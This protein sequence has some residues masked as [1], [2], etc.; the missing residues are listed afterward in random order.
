MPSGREEQNSVQGL[1]QES[2]Q[3]LGPTDQGGSVVLEETPGG[4]G[5]DDRDK[6]DVQD[7]ALG[8]GGKEITGDEVVDQPVQAEARRARGGRLQA[9]QAGGDVAGKGQ[10]EQG[11]EG[12]GHRGGS[13]VVSEGAATDAPEI[14]SA[15]QRGVDGDQNQRQ[16]QELEDGDEDLPEPGDIG[17]PGREKEGQG[18]A[19]QESAGDGVKVAQGHGGSWNGLDRAARG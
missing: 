17:S 8:Q 13:E 19:Q 11:P 9:Q 10:A 1:H 12:G 5:R 4:Q 3:C 2:V 7:V 6:D 14:V 18:D 16:D 15:G